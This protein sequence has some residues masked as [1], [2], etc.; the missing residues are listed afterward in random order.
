M[1]STMTSASGDAD[2]FREELCQPFA[3]EVVGEL[4]G[5]DQVDR[6]VGEG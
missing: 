6:A 2:H 5:R 1:S 4:D 3:M